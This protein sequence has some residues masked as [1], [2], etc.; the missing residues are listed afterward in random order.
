MF[1]VGGSPGSNSGSA[2]IGFGT[3]LATG[4]GAAASGAAPIDGA[5]LGVEG[6][7]GVAEIPPLFAPAIFSWVR[8]IAAIPSTAPMAMWNRPAPCSVSGFH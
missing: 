4:V 5:E 1:L 2:A 3:G 6:L 8:P 7:L